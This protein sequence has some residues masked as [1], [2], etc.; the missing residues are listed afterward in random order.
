VALLLNVQSLTKSYG[1][2]PLFRDIS[3]NV[4]EADR[5]GIVGPNGSGKSTMLE[6]LGG[7][8][9]PDS[10]EVAL[11]KNTRLSYVAQDSHFATGDSIRK[12]LQKALAETNVPPGDWAARE[13]ETLGRV[14]FPDFEAEAATLSGGWRKRV[15]IAQALV[16]DPDI[17]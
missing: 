17:L 15:A 11:R 10:G 8:R 16:S 7:L 9:K 2:N 6:L 14:G 4:S 1:A 13:A 12:V 5:L 3:F